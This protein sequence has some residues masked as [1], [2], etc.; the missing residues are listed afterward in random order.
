M[1]PVVVPVLLALIFRPG[2]VPAQSTNFYTDTVT[3]NEI[4]PVAS[5]TGIT[6]TTSN[7]TGLS[8]QISDLTVTLDIGSAPGNTAFNGDLYAYLAG[9]NGGFA[10]LLNRTG[11]TGENSFGYS[12]SGFDVTFALSAT[13]NIHLYQEYPFNINEAGQLTGT[14][15][16]DGLAIDPQS[17]PSLFD[18]T[19]PTAFLNSFQGMN[20][21]GLWTL[22]VADLGSGNESELLNWSVNITTVPEPSAWALFALGILLATWKRSGRPF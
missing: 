11:V 20:P 16:P 13:D 14:W 5:S 18:S 10:V 17:S 12:D 1:K 6:S 22:F 9:P 7:L 3:A 21:N 19:T 4:V 2:S 8:G 15:Q